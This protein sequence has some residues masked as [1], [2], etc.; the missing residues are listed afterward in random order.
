MAKVSDIKVKDRMRSIDLEK[1]GELADSIKEL[2]LLNPITV[3]MEN[4]EMVLKAGRHRLEAFKALGL[5]EIPVEIK[6]LDPL[7]SELVEIDENLIRAELHFIDRGEHLARRKK[8]YEMLYPAIQHGG[9]R[10]SQEFETKR[11]DDGLKLKESFTV[12]TAKKTGFK[13]R[14]IQ[15]DVQIAT[16]LDPEVKQEVKKIDLG[17]QEALKLAR[18]RNPQV[19]K[20]IVG[21][22][23]EGTAKTVKQ[24]EA[25]I[26]VEKNIKRG[27]SE[28]MT[29]DVTFFDAGIEKM[30]TLDP[31][32]VS[33]IVTTPPD[34]TQYEN[35]I[36]KASR[37]LK[38]GGIIALQASVA[39]IPTILG[40]K[41]ESIS[42]YWIVAN[43][44]GS[45]K[46]HPE[47]VKS[48]WA[49]VVVLIKGFRSMAAESMTDRIEKSFE[50]LNQKEDYALQIVTRF[51]K[52]G[53]TVLD[54]FVS[55]NF[56]SYIA[57]CV[58][59]KY[60]GLS[61]NE[62]DVAYIKSQLDELNWAV[63]MA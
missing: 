43:M 57:A 7:R 56:V 30:D 25:Q 26:A 37:I 63:A 23:A 16:H 41:S 45:S 6:N 11:T 31:E 53:E 50:H 17:K 47:G 24:A 44:M 10:R 59:R 58:G 12:D 54:P 49:P 61:Q 27:R 33:A 38:T 36:E 60:I 51:T 40:I 42:F 35:L 18:I 29:L 62:D 34:G 55:R 4:N 48:N 52:M 13:P 20:D 46:N 2:G 9:D 1:V 14:T 28:K 21:K 5:E 22:I 8:I 3:A 19:Q 15:Q 39:D 32:S